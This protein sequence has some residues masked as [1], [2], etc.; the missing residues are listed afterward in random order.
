MCNGWYPGDQ[1]AGSFAALFTR[2]WERDISAAFKKPSGRIEY[3][4]SIKINQCTP[5]FAWCWGYCSGWAAVIY[6]LNQYSDF[7]PLSIEVWYKSYRSSQ[8]KLEIVSKLISVLIF[9]VD[10]R[11]AGYD[12]NLNRLRYN[13]YY[14]IGMLCAVL[15]ILLTSVSGIE[16]ELYILA[17]NTGMWDCWRTWGSCGA[18]W[19]RAT[20][21]SSVFTPGY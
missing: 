16:W 19:R 8:K 5:L 11:F 6:I 4:L 18:T 10:C 17:D 2:S 15:R 9:I 12:Y 3:S 14:H 20:V 13:K 21:G 7:Q 1:C